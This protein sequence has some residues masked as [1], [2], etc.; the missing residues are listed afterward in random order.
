MLVRK[1]V[2]DEV[3]GFDADYFMYYEDVDL[4]WRIRLRGY[5]I[6]FAA[7][8]IVYHRTGAAGGQFH[9]MTVPSFYSGRNYIA[10]LVKNYETGNLLMYGID[11]LI[12]Q[13]VTILYLISKQ[14]AHEAF[15]LT[16]ALLAAA[17][18][19]RRNWKKR[20]IVQNIR[21]VSDAQILKHARH[22]TLKDLVRR[23]NFDK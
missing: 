13:S 22:S 20:V 11:H 8:S 15:G 18:D 6:D 5:S 14:R 10:T 16:V 17:K 2:F 3:D 9:A 1:R 23:R 19:F 4:S 7:S 21:L 12:V